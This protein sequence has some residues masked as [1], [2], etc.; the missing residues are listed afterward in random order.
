[1]PAIVVINQ[2]K[3]CTFSYAAIYPNGPV[4][5]QRESGILK[6][7][8]TS[9]NTE[10]YTFTNRDSKYDVSLIKDGDS[11]FI[12]IVGY[13]WRLSGKLKNYAE[14]TQSVENSPSSNQENSF[15]EG[16]SIYDTSNVQY[17]DSSSSE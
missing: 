15:S 13:N 7:K 4:E 8:Q 2:L 9:G 12:E 10:Y 6:F 17:I 14:T 1:M 16:G 5:T 3:E 11:R